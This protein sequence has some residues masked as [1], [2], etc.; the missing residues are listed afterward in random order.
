[1]RLFGLNVL[2]DKQLDVLDIEKKLTEQLEL[3]ERRYQKG[4]EREWADTSSVIAS[5][6]GSYEYAHRR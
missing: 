3:A 1:M 2:T 6:L 5:A 4:R